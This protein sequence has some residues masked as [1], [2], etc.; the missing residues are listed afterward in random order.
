M[1]LPEN[2]E[3][4]AEPT[5][6]PQRKKFDEEFAA[7]FNNFCD[8]ALPTI[9]ELH[10]IAVIPIW[11]N[12]PEKTPSGLLRLQNPNPPYTESLL[13]LLK[14]LIAFIA[15]ANSDLL[16]QMRIADQYAAELA[17]EIKERQEKLAQPPA[18]KND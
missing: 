12:Q 15:D 13:M 16:L 11:T 9:P 10:G 14:R 17:A 18:A 1:T 3:N 5:K 2:A 7:Q 6:T 4:T 8:N